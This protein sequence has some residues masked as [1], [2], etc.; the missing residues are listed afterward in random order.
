MTTRLILARVRTEAR[1]QSDVRDTLD[2]I[3]AMVA[4]QQLADRAV[5]SI[6]LSAGDAVV[7]SDRPLQAPT[8]P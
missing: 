7:Q 1:R 5:L 8:L 4:A 2:M 6:D 3:H